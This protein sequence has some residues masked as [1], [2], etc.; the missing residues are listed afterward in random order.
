MLQQL[1]IAVM[2]L[3]ASA[4]AFTS[5]RPQ[6]RGLHHT[7]L[8]EKSNSEDDSSRRLFFSSVAV[9]AAIAIPATAA[10]AGIDVRSLKNLPVEGDATGAATRM[11]QLQQQGT[12]MEAVDRSV[13]MM[14]PS[15]VSYREYSPG[16]DGSV[17][18]KPGSKVGTEMAVRANG[19]TYYNTKDDADFND[20][21]WTIGSGEYTAALEEG[22][23]GMKPKSKRIIVVPSNLVFAARNAGQLPE[24]MSTDRTYERLFKSGDATLIFEVVV[25]RIN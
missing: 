23:L 11:K 9:A 7:A 22:M 25:T 2:M 17:V 24:A 10:N 21:A 13:Q 12:Q 1:S 6:V 4:G 18:V 5:F 14:L 19:V 3:L 8:S 16:K 20:L 15:G